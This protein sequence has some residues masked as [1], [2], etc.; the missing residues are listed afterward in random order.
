M[1]QNLSEDWLFT[2][3]NLNYLI[4]MNKISVKA[5]TIHLVNLII[6]L[7]FYVNHL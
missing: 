1:C 5:S 6:I 2:F 4:Q 7:M 3:I